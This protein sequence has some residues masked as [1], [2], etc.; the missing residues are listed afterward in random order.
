MKKIEKSQ[1]NEI[2]SDEI[3]VRKNKYYDS[4]KPLFTVA[5]PIYNRINNIERTLNSVKKSR[6]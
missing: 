6:L 5:T 1:S 2:N 3:I 4:A